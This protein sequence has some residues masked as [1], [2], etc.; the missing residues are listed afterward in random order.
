MRKKIFI[1]FLLL[2][3][4]ARGAD[5]PKPAAIDWQDWSPSI[6][7]KAKAEKKLVIL[8][9]HAV[10]CHWCHVMD[11]QTYADPKVADLIRTKYIAIGVDQDSRPDLAS[12]YEDYGWPA[13]IIFDANGNE[14]AKR[15]GFIP[16]KEMASML[17]AFI[18]DPTP[19]PSV[20]NEKPVQ[21]SAQSSLPDNLRDE[22]RAALVKGYDAKYGSWGTGGQKFMDWDNVEYCMGEARAGDAR[23]EKMAKQT[24]TAQTKLI[25]PAWGG[26][27][28]YSTDGDWEHPHFEKLIQFQAENMRTYARAYA[29]W[30]DSS[31]LH[32]AESIHRYVRDF[33]TS[34]G[35]GFF[36]SQDADVVPGEH[37]GEYFKLGDAARRRIGMPRVD[38]HIYARENGWMINALV[39]LY[40]A[41][42]DESYLNEAI[43]TAKIMLEKRSLPSGGW[44]H[45]SANQSGPFLG[46]ALSMGRALLALY[47]ATGD[48]AW[49]DRASSTAD[50]I[51]DRCTNLEYDAKSS[52]VVTTAYSDANV[53]DPKPEFDE[54]VAV[55]RFANLLAHY[56]ASTSH[57]RLAECA[58][59]YLVTPE[60]A[61]KRG[62]YC[63]GLLLA[64]TEMNSDPLHVVVVGGKDD[65][66]AKKLFTAATRYPVV[67]KQ[68]EWQDK[69]EPP[70]HKE[71]TYPDIPKAAA[72]ICTN[73]ACS[74]PIYNPEELAP[75]IDRLLAKGSGASTLT[76]GFTRP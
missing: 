13:T 51:V 48:H 5:A 6:F 16:P 38:T 53:A 34:T 18:D 61:R 67:Y 22:M 30:G 20:T 7:E 65:P 64:D 63:G 33:L 46:D 68:V 66:V 15:R 26:V 27:Y 54:N 10:W 45:D 74:A 70:L 52:G 8:D 59:R 3:Q 42:G 25:D 62:A 1:G 41:T 9:L 73:G 29:Q 47:A 21:Y 14:L 56:E 50:F 31:D 69:K 75:H 17:Q 4:L 57:R 32:A 55:A 76:P 72:Y 36:T 44:R 43:A 2:V 60:I 12:R 11:E 19:G 58:M 23:L 71:I 39:Q 40:I 35:G 28:Q 49:L 37:A 24:L